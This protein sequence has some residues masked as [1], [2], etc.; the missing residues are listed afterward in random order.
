MFV[1]G[2]R[3]LSVFNGSPKKG[4]ASRVG[5]R[6]H[7]NSKILRSTSQRRSL[8]LGKAE[9]NSRITSSYDPRPFRWNDV[10]TMR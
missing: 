5:L 7:G 1:V 3:G 6:F 9:G 8:V 10:A 4:Y 2:T